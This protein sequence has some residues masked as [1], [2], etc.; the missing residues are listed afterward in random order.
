MIDEGSTEYISGVGDVLTLFGWEG[1]R[2]VFK[3]RRGEGG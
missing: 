2:V 3:R 1:N